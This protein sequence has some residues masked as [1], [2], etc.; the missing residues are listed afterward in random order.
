MERLI[1]G[2]EISVKAPETSESSS[3]G[4]FSFSISLRRGHEECGDSAFVFCDG[5]KFMAGVFD[6][7]SGEPGA[8]A[9]SS[10]ASEAILARL[11]DE[12]KISEKALKEAILLANRSIKKGFTTATVICLESDGAFII[13][14]VGDSLAYGIDSRG[15][16]SSELPQSRSVGDDHSILKLVTTVLGPSGIDISMHVRKGRLKKGEI[17]IL[18][19]DG[20]S[21]NL[22]V[23]VKEGY[24]SDTAGTE[25][26]GVILGAE[27]DPEKICAKLLSEVKARMSGEKTE[28]PGRMLIPKHDD[29]AIVAVKLL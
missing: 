9:A 8:A 27:R 18:A 5:K 3:I 14:G 26:L 2:T 19:T 4:P 23:K 24:V 22:F 7:V 15:E 12:K 29:V 11:K 16:V 1:K 25:D 21:D 6:G 10:I 20:L 17:L 28:L 13:A